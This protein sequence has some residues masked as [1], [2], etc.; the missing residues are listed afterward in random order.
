MAVLVPS[1]SLSSGQG[2]HVHQRHHRLPVGG[3]HHCSL[4][5]P[6]GEIHS[7][8]VTQRKFEKNEKYEEYS[9]YMEII[10]LVECSKALMPLMNTV[11]TFREGRPN[12]CWIGGSISHKSCTET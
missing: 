6:H 5:A 10:S 3:L 7:A 1:R 8:D 2:V 9:K 11:Y 12:W 4:R